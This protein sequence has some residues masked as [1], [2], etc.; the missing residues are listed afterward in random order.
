[1]AIDI[2]KIG[3]II[4]RQQAYIGSI[5]GELKQINGEKMK[6][7]KNLT[8]DANHYNTI[9]NKISNNEQVISNKQQLIYR[10]ASDTSDD[11]RS[12]NKL[13]ESVDSTSSKDYSFI[14]EKYCVA[15]QNL[16]RKDIFSV[17]FSV[18]GKKSDHRRSMNIDVIFEPGDRPYKY[19]V[20]MVGSRYA[21]EITNRIRDEERKWP[22]WDM[23]I[24]AV[25]HEG[26]MWGKL[27]NRTKN[28]KIVPRQRINYCVAGLDSDA[29]AHLIL[30][31]NTK[32]S[33]QLEDVK[34]IDLRKLFIAKGTWINPEWDEGD[35]DVKL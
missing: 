18:L 33:C 4:V 16:L 15:A 8:S 10:F 9:N 27:R 6:D 12:T 23:V 3:Y 26:H 30:G 14:T 31:N 24:G 1:M 21:Y 13:N 29:V 35:Y 17:S 34:D 25:K 22:M 32:I 11:K 2:H 7:Q 20:D 28:T 5:C 19:K